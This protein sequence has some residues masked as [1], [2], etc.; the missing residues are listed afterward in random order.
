MSLKTLRDRRL[1]KQRK[2]FFKNLIK[3]FKFET[4]HISLDLIFFNW[5]PNFGIIW[6]KWDKKI[7]F[8]R[9]IHYGTAPG[10]FSK[11][12][13]IYKKFIIYNKYKWVIEYKQSSTSGPV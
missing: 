2:N 4:G 10:Y 12:I 11:E 1:K 9:H 6:W 13:I 3:F 5:R 7:V 8:Y